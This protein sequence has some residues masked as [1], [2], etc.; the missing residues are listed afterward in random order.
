MN[1]TYDF[2]YSQTGSV[3]LII[4]SLIHFNFADMARLEASSLVAV[5]VINLFMCVG[6]GK[7][8]FSLHMH[9]STY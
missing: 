6:Q 8:Q 3:G 2:S 4:K 5:V 9:V 7:L 1:I